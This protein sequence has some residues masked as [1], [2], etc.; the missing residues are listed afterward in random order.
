MRELFVYYRVR[1]ADAPAALAAVRQLHAQ[2][3]HAYPGLRA[4]LLHRP[5]DDKDL[6]T[7]M[8]TYQTDPTRDG[9]A[10]DLQADIE[11][12]AHALLAPLLQ[13]PRHTEVFI[14]CAS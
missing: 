4:R 3:R 7:W 12:R 8:E 9:M 6:Q 1:P 2:L 13:G 11:A 14:A 5:D 10:A